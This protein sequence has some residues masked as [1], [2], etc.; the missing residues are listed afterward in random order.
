MLDASV[1]ILD[2]AEPGALRFRAHHGFL[3][4]SRLASKETKK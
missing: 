2:G 3:E 1:F 4:H